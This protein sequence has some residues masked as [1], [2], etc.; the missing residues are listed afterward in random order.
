MMQCRHLQRS[1]DFDVESGLV[2]KTLLH[3]VGKFWVG[4]GRCVC[5]SVFVQRGK[6]R[7]TAGGIGIAGVVL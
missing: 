3:R 6:D 4:F 5:G 2:A 7:E 1:Q